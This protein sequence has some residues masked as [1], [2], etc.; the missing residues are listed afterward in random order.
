MKVEIESDHVPEESD[1]RPSSPPKLFR[2]VRLILVRNLVDAQN[3][4][5]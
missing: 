4:V 1:T 5:L 3:M 2:L